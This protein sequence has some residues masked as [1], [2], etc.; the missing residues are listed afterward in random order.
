MASKER[1]LIDRAADEFVSG[2]NHMEIIG[3]GLLRV[4]FFVNVSDG[5]A[6]VSVPANHALVMPLC[7]LPDAIGK[8]IATSSHSIFARAD[9][10]TLR[11][12]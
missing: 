1:R 2:V 8:A 4:T 11:M 3:G 5:G 12:H 10:L 9:G 7:A 6:L